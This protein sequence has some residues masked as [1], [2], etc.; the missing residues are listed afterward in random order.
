[1]ATT[2]SGIFKVWLVGAVSPTNRK[3][4]YNDYGEGTMFSIGMR[5]KSL[6][7]Q[8]CQH[9]NSTFA[10]ADYSWELGNVADTDVVVYCFS[11][12]DRGILWRGNSNVI[13]QSANGG[14]GLYNGLMVSEIYLAEFSGATAYATRAANLIF[15]EIMHNKLDAP[16]V[17]T[18]DN[19]HK[20]GGGGLAEES[21]SPGSQLT[22][23]NIELMAGALAKKVPQYTAEMQKP[24]T[25]IER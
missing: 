20:K 19:L 4:Q 12:K 23:R 11:T 17:K 10:A 5:L 14:T 1:M 3:F 22:P 2:K 7:D 13:H 25:G 18:I 21:V 8:V 6:F 24:L 15:H 9:K 16:A